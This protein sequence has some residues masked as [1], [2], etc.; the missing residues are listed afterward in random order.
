ML[1]FTSSLYLGLQHPS[2]SLPAWDSLTLGKPAALEEA[3]GATAVEW[4]LAALTGC[5]DVML[6]TSTLHAFFD[7]FALL[8]GPRTA[9]FIDQSS[10]PVARWAAKHST[11]STGI[12]SRSHDAEELRSAL[13]RVRGIRPII[14]T[15][16]ISPAAGSLAPFA[17]YA[18]LASQ[19]GGLVLVDDTQALGVFG[20]RPS[21]SHPYG[22]DGGGSLRSAGI[23]S[24]EV[25]LVSSL[26]KAFGVPVAMVGGSRQLMARLRSN[27][28]TR[29]HC[30]PPSRAVIEAAAQALCLNER[31]GEALRARL[32]RNVAT[33]RRGLNSLG[34]AASQSL[35]PVQPLRLAG[36]FAVA[37][38]SKL[39]QYGVR[40]VL[41]RCS[42]SGEQLSF[43]ITACHTP[44]Q[45]GNAID[46]LAH[47][48]GTETHPKVTGVHS[49]DSHA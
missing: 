34:L 1:D 15:D 24:E 19:R 25:V 7:L 36:N 42:S 39:L 41:Q 16:G 20:A 14:V 6:G 35:F 30:S 10:Y 38:H 26:A 37:V 46:A 45:I 31:Y 28:L 12:L 44:Q 29:T 17:Q 3:P 49:H 9:V 23:H 18:H 8:A 13:S 27:S 33:F 48:I 2:W 4:E 5:D 47:A 22:V 32:A 21:R 40:A 43:L 11:G